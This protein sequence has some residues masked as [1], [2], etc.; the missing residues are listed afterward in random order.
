MSKKSVKLRQEKPSNLY[1]LPI[2]FVI[3]VVPLIVFMKL[4]DLSPIE[5]KN[6]YGEPTYTDFFNFYKSQWLIIGTIMAA[7]F[8]LVHALIKGFELKKSFFY[9]PTAI[10]AILIILS[11]VFSENPQIALRGFVARYE[12]MLALL[13]Y[14]ALM[15]ITYNLVRHESQIK[16]LLGALLISASVI[17]I[18]GVFQFVGLDIFRSGFGKRLILP[19]FAHQAADSLSFQFEKS[20][21]HSTFSNTN[22]IGSYIVLVIPIAFAFFLYFRRPWQKIATAILVVILF[23]CLIGSKSSAGLVGLGVSVLIAIVLFRKAIFKR[24][25]MAIAGLV[26]IPILIFGANYA[27][28]GALVNRILA[29]FTQ[30]NEVEYMDLKDIVFGENSVSIIS[31]TEIE[32][33]TIKNEDAELAFYDAK[34]KKINHVQYDNG[35]VELKNSYLKNYSIK[36]EGNRLTFIQKGVQIKLI[37]TENGGFELIGINGD[38]TSA[39]EKPEIIGFA[40]NERLGSSRGYIWSRTLPKL[41]NAL[42]IGYGPDCF[43]I[44]FPQKDYI[45]KI[46]AFGTAQMIVDKPHN[47]YLQIATNSGV[48]AL[49]AVLTICG[50]YIIK[51]LKLYAKNIEKNFLYFSG[52]CIFLAICGY[53]ST[54]FFNDSVV[55]IAPIFWVFLGLGLACNTIIIQS[56]S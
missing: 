49:L 28:N 36:V 5:I 12:G 27:L 24:K 23:V 15:V 10:Y 47:T 16:F 37:A 21:V 26:S 3:T 39:I 56:K 33:L 25:M 8:Y 54:S 50:Y 13:C 55:G 35:Y 40:G 19:E 20:A 6:W 34:N 45:G 2:A 43:A 38:N 29:E 9:I 11:T 30:D 41:K 48:L 42:F 52:T 4:V 14:L 31:G 46:R 22:Y 1:I 53:L 18:I 17:G 51:S 32:T 44:I 7:L